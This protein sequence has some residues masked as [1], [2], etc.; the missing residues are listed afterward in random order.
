[1]DTR[2]RGSGFSIWLNFPRSRNFRSGVSRNLYTDHLSALSS[3]NVSSI[4]TS[5]WPEV[6]PS[7]ISTPSFR[8]ASSR[9]G[10]PID[11]SFF[12]T[13]GALL[14]TLILVGRL[15]SAFARRR[16]TSAL[17]MLDALQVRMIKLVESNGVWSILPSS[18]MSGTFSK[19]SGEGVGV[20]PTPRVGVWTQ[21]TSSSPCSRELR[22]IGA[23]TLA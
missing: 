7:P 15:M 13:S 6:L 12:D 18:F 1:V 23:T 17:D 9:W 14:V 8:S 19:A 16:A 4:W 21:P 20:I 10:K 22:C 11:D 3:Y 5:L 2:S